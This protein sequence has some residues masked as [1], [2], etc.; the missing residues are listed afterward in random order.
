MQR[1]ESKVYHTYESKYGVGDKHKFLIINNEKK[2]FQYL[3]LTVMQMDVGS[4]IYENSDTLNVKLTMI[5]IFN[6]IYK[7]QIF[8]V[9]PK[10]RGSNVLN[11]ISY[12]TYRLYLYYQNNISLF[13]QNVMFTSHEHDLS[14]L[15]KLI[16]VI[17]L[18]G[19]VYNQII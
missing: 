12:H 6:K 19:I 7:Q 1:I 10:F 11:V 14:I 3:R 2:C 9:K 17:K 18:Q 15:S 5:C 4:S 13:I 16:V 8:K